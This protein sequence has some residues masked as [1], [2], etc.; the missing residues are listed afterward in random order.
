MQARVAQALGSEVRSTQTL[1]GGDLSDVFRVDLSD[2]RSILVKSGPLVGR[3]ARMLLAIR[4]TGAQVPAILWSGDQLLCLEWLQETRAARAGWQALG[5]TLHVLHAAAGSD[6]GWDEDYAFG[7]LKIDNRACAD[8]PAF[9]AERRLLPFVTDLAPP[10]AN[11]VETLAMDVQNRLPKTPTPA[12][13]HGDLWTGNTLFSG[14]H[15]WL[16]DPA[17]YHGDAEVDLAMLELFGRP[18][19]AFWEGYGKT[20]PGREARRPIYQLWPALVHLSLFGPP[21]RAMVERLLDQA[22][23]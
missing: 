3:E 23:A 4:D 22:G 21:Y 8:W 14:P 1:Q 13:L 20:M 5:K 7:L 19:V 16:I 6:Y 15:A 18:D 9:W 17:S 10:L 11:R 12:L 2:G